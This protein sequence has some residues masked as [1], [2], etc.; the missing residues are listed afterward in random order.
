MLLEATVVYDGLG[1]S[2]KEGDLK[3]VPRVFHKDYD[4]LDSYF[5]ALEERFIV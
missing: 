2:W 4:G 5:L 1:L 3:G